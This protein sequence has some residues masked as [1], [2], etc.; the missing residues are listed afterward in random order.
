MQTRNSFAVSLLASVVVLSACAEDLTTEK[1][2]WEATQKEWAAKVEKTKKSQA[3]L[4]A[5]LKAFVVPE[6]E[7]ALVAAKADVEKSVAGMGTALVDAEKAMG[8][9]KAN[10]DGLIA[11]GKKVQLEVALG[12]TKSSVDGVLS[13]A[14]SLVNAGASGLE[15]LERKLATAKAE[16]DAAKSRTEAW[17]GEVKKKGGMMSID[18]I[19]FA[20]DALTV[21]KSRVALTSLV[22]TL[23]ACAELRVE[24]T[25]TAN[26]DAAELSTK[27]AEALKAYLVG[28]TVD[29]AVFAT[30]TGKSEKDAEEKVAVTVTTPCK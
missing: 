23:K 9:A 11:K 1:A 30:V 8:A 25:V 6:G 7:T 22:A 5:K 14:D 15:Q 3:E 29:A 13:R 27:R 18:D 2:T 12:T 24:V 21:E 17:A 20:A 19:V 4:D 16:G 28:K 26:S 10:I